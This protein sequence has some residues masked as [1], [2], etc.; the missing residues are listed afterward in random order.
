[1][2]EKPLIQ[3]NPYLKNSSQRD[4]LLLIAANTS[5]AVEGIHVVI[6]SYGKNNRGDHSP[7]L[8]E[9]RA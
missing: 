5:T 7:N 9:K 8:F 2:S 4:W 3:T 6:P 1:M